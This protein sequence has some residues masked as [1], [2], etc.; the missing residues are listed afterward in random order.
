MGTKLTLIIVVAIGDYL[1]PN[2]E[3]LLV[4]LKKDP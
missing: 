2:S 4:H 1:W 3:Q